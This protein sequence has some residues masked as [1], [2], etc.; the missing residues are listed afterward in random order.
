LVVVDQI[1]PGSDPQTRFIVIGTNQKT[2]TD[3]D[4]YAYFDYAREVYIGTGSSPS[5][6][7]QPPGAG[8]YAVGSYFTS[9]APSTVE[10]DIQNGTKHVFKQ[11][12]PPDGSTFP[13]RDLFFTVNTTGTAVAEYDTFYLLTL[14]SDY[15]AINEQSWEKKDSTATWNLSLHAVPMESPFWAFLGG[16]IS[17]VN[18]SGSQLITGP[19]T[20][21][22]VWRP[23]YIPAIIAILIILLVIAGLGYL[24]YRIRWWAIPAGRPATRTGVKKASSKAKKRASK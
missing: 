4:N 14:K 2:V 20:V 5:G 19:T 1:I 9:T 6:L 17:P 18:A 11:W 10:S 16:T 3:I 21:E 24:T 12:R 13:N 7:I 8:F 15:P 22:I 23:N